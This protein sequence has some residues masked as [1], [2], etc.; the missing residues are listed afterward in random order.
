MALNLVLVTGSRLLD[1][2]VR[3]FTVPIVL[4]YFGRVDYGLIALAFSLQAFLMIADFGLGVNAVKQISQYLQ[5]NR[6]EEI[7]RLAAAASFFYGLIG[8]LNLALLLAVGSLGQRLFDLDEA[9]ADEF[10]WMMLALG[11]SSAITWAA[12]IYRQILNAAS[13][14]GWDE[15]VNLLSSVLTLAAIG[16]T[17]HWR[18]SPATYF[19]LILIPPLVP[20]I[21]R[22]HRVLRLVPGMRVAVSPDW[23]LFRPLINT[24]AWL[25]ALMLAEVTAANCRPMILSQRTGL[26][27]VADFR[28]LQQIAG[29]VLVV[30]SGFMSVIYPVVARLDAANDHARI[31]TAV[32]SGS[33]LLLWGHLAV[34]VPIAFVSELMLRLYLGAEFVKLAG[35]LSVWVLTLFAYHNSILTSLVMTRGR[36]AILASTAVANSLL[37]LFLANYFAPEYGVKAVVYSYSLYIFL[38]LSVMYLVAAPSA[39]AGPGLALISKVFTKPILSAT[40]CGVVALGTVEWAAVELWWGALLYVPLFMGCAATL[41][42]APADWLRLRAQVSA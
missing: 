7:A 34:L 33:R 28:V 1:G 4:H 2:A 10:F 31:A 13:M 16:A 6:H 9:K 35:T 24:S 36:L 8:I 21:L 38:Q 5:Q 17:L 19:A 22:I 3:F 41:G 15:S 11:L 14:V 39:G 37:T 30:L 27:S 26:A 20:M 32:T 18:L 29:L 25:F 23:P 40:I 42:G 12:S